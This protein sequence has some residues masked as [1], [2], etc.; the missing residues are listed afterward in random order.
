MKSPLAGNWVSDQL[1]LLFSESQ[2]PVKIIPHYMVTSKTAVEAGAAAQATYR[3]FARPPK[4]TFKR[5]QEERVLTEFKESCVQI[6][7]PMNNQG[8]NLAGSADYI[9][10]LPGRTFEFPDG[11]NNVFNYDR[12]RAAEGMFDEKMA[13]TDANNS[14]PTAAQTVPNMVRAA[15]AAVDVDIKPHLLAN[16]VVTGG[17]SLI[18]GFNDRLNFEIQSQWQGSRVRI[19]SPGSLADRQYAPWIGGSILASLGAFHQ[20]W[21]SKKGMFWCC[22]MFLVLAEIGLTLWQSTMRVDR[23]LWR[24]GASRLKTGNK[25]RKR[26]RPTKPP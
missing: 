22:L 2:P 11:W 23:V 10:S 14:A 17:S 25:T 19:Q 3:Q 9:K 16:V 6:W 4:D 12:F 13:L 20:M 18:N 15:L 24:S 7:N 8:Q 1:R 21:I 5:L 26:A